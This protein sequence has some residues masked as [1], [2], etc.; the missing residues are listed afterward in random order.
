MGLAAAAC[1]T[2]CWLRTRRPAEPCVDSHLACR[3]QHEVEQA[4]RSLRDEASSA[5]PAVRAAVQGAGPTV[6]DGSPAAVLERQLAFRDKLVDSLKVK[7]LQLLIRARGATPR[8]D[9][10]GPRLRVALAEQAKG[11]PPATVAAERATPTA[12][13]PEWLGRSTLLLGEEA[14]AKLAASRVLVVGLG[15]V[16]RYIAHVYALSAY[17]NYKVAFALSAGPQSSWFAVVWAI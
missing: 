4:E 16:G 10:T 3:L 13:A 15:G 11:L 5:A 14:M 8:I 9:I 6:A 12:P 1:C 7:E 2:C 17:S